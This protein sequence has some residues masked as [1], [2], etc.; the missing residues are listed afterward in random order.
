MR[1]D[2]TNY[3]PSGRGQGDAT[4]FRYFR[5]SKISPK[6]RKLETAHFA[7]WCIRSVSFRTKTNARTGPGHVMICC[8]VAVSG[9]VME[10]VSPGS[11]SARRRAPRPGRPRCSPP[12]DGE[13]A[14]VEL[15]SPPPRP[16][17]RS[18]AVSPSRFRALSHTAA[19]RRR[20][21][22]TAWQSA[23]SY[24]CPSLVAAAAAASSFTATP[25]NYW[26]VFLS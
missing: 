15:S 10:G 2:A 14:T 16:K 20:S 26:T 22:S 23:T 11:V 19:A 8:F 1:P 13:S 9:S 25:S 12:P 17:L 18:I 7:H 4:H 6:R 5:P 3:P 21:H 24:L